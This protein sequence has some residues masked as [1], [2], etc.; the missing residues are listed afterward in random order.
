MI[1]ARVIVGVMGT[2]KKAGGGAGEGATMVG[3]LK[4]PPCPHT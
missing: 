3:A 1:E 2:T 4:G